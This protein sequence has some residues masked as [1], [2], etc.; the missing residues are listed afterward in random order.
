MGYSEIGRYLKGYVIICGEG[1]FTE[2]FV[3]ICIRRNLEI[4]DIKKAGEERIYAKMSIKSFK[5]IRQ[6]CGRTK[7]RVRI[8][9]KQG[10]PFI[11]KKAVKRKG[12]LIGLLAV[13]A[14]IWYTTGHIMG[15]TVFGNERISTET[16][17]EHLERSGIALGKTTSGIDTDKIR[18][19]MMIDLND[20]A[21]IGINV[22]GSRV[23]VEV[24][25]RIEKEMG[26]DMESPCHLVATR[27]GIIE[28]LKIRNGQ[29]MVKENAGV[30]EGD[31]LVSGIVDNPVSGFNY[32]HAYGE[33]YAITE[34]KKTAEYPLEY[35]ENSYTG[36]S[37]KRYTV[38]ILDKE[39]PLF[40][41]KKQPFEKYETEEEEREYRLI[42][43][44][45]PSVNVKKEVYRQQ[46]EEKKKRSAKEAA[47]VGKEELEKE[48]RLEIG[49]KE[50]KEIKSTD[51]ITE[52]GTVEVTVTILC[53]ENI[54]REVPVEIDINT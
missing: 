32:V 30:R 42:I 41:G 27:D 38:K 49:E 47:S 36:K 21:W 53:R 8:V 39:I 7:T 25:E 50:I 26:V 13:I 11:T 12:A 34:Y 20:L 2:R 14:I 52:R 5:E 54:A 37:K 28:S 15:I 17:L 44:S 3:N 46:T 1:V 18:N 43:E 16:V 35:I 23:Y 48:L 51:T 4:W 24:V 31:V 9:K 6:I 33:V 45:L 29:T 40:I 22:S 10:L 19:R